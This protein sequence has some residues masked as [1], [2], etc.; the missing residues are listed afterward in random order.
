[1]AQTSQLNEQLTAVKKFITRRTSLVDDLNAKL[2]ELVGKASADLVE[3]VGEEIIANLDAD[4]GRILNNA[5]NRKLLNKLDTLYNNFT[6]GAGLDVVNSMIAGA[7]QIVSLNTQY[8]SIFQVPKPELIKLSEAAMTD[9]RS[10]LGVDE[11]GKLGENG[12]LKTLVKSEVI[13]NQLKQTTLESIATQQGYQQFKTNVKEFIKGNPN[14]TGKLEQYY[15]NYAYDTYSV[16]DRTVSNN[17]GDKLGLDYAIY[18]GGI[19]ATTRAFCKAHN[20]KVYTRDEISK[21]WPTEARQ[22]NYNPFTDM[23]GYACRHHY[24]WINYELAV[25]LRPDLANTK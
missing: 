6:Q 11:T 24:N 23:G 25:H 12:Y 5:K 10:W 3:S 9:V 20:G 15:R 14:K 17:M 1:M 22:P 7:T 21:F 19:I 13:R 18:E 8:A 16:I 4:R 2:E